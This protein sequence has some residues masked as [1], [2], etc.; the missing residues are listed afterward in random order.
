MRTPTLA[1]LIALTGAGCTLGPNYVRPNVPELPA[2]RIEYPKAA[3]VAN[4]KWWE[5]FGD[6]VLNGLIEDALKENL[7]VQVAAARVDQFRGAL[8]STRSQGMPQVGYGASVNETRASRL[9]QP[10]VPEPNDPQFSLYQTSIG[11][12]WQIDL[13]GRVRRLSEAA[14]AQIYASEQAQRGV[15]LTLVTDLAST[16][17]ALRGFDRQR[18]IAVAT[19][20]N[21]AETARI[22]DLRFRSGIVSMS[23]VSQI[24]SQQMLAL[25][26][27]PALEQQIAVLENLISLLLGRPSQ[28]IPRGKSITELVAPLI[29]EDLPSTLLQRRPDILQAEQNLIAVNANIGATRTLYYP[30]ISL[31]GLLG[32]VSTV[33]GSFLTGPATAWQVGA[34]AVGPIFTAGGI[35]GQV[36]SA[37]AA[38][39]QAVPVY[40]QTILN[41]FR[42]TNNA[43]VGSQKKIQELAYQQER[44]AAL[45]EFGR[46]ARLRF[47]QGMSGY[48]EVLVADNERFAAELQSVRILV[49]R[50]TQVV[51]VYQALG[52]GWV[53]VANAIVPVKTT[54]PPPPPAK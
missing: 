17:L 34:G 12:S 29:P 52:G 38:Y 31:T 48:F 5:Q 16:Y 25:A 44:V 41:A 45:T 6:P 33:F 53:D 24:K 54:P 10:P 40:Q 14:Q 22:F 47:E 15:V 13:F 8:A 46:L 27:I 4:T 49:D 37:E 35:K 42:E 39:A 9:G 20:A 26:A 18:E 32:S 19:A 43:L 28:A 7:Q 23:E 51:N 11:A 2:W 1:L 30:T 21:F 36:R 3:E 50:H